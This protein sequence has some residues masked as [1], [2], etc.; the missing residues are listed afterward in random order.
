MNMNVTPIN[1]RTSTARK[2]RHCV[3]DAP[4]N[5]EKC[6]TGKCK[7]YPRRTKSPKRRSRFSTAGDGLTWLDQCRDVATLNANPERRRKRADVRPR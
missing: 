6:R 5:S 3:P 1:C 7:L 2:A 4:G